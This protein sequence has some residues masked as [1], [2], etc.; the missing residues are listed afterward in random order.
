MVKQ[1]VVLGELHEIKRLLHRSLE[2][3]LLKENQDA[4]PKIIEK[5]A[6]HLL[7]DAARDHVVQIDDDELLDLLDFPRKQ[8]SK[9]LESQLR[10]L[11]AASS[12]LVDSAAAGAA[13]VD[14]GLLTVRGFK[15]FCSALATPGAK[16]VLS[17]YLQMEA[18]LF[19]QTKRVYLKTFEQVPRLDHVYIHKAAAE[20]ESDCHKI[21]KTANVSRRE[22]QLNTSLA[23]G[24]KMVY[25]RATFNADIVE[26]V[27]A[28]VLKRYHYWREHYQCR[29]Y[30]SSNILDVICVVLDTLASCHENI[31]RE[32]MIDRVLQAVSDLLED[33]PEES[34]EDSQDSEDSHDSAEES[35]IT[36][37]SNKKKPTPTLKHTPTPS[38]TQDNSAG[39]LDID[40]ALDEILC[41]SSPRRDSERQTLDFI[42]RHELVQRVSARFGKVQ[43]GTTRA[44]KMPMKQFVALLD[45]AMARR[46]CPY[47]ESTQIQSA[48]SGPEVVR[49]VY[50]NCRLAPDDSS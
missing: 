18:V 9:L 40:D 28:V 12:S 32:G 29:A 41:F 4:G 50:L 5:L 1:D 46:G 38:K 42:R 11:A 20:E 6:E 36:P 19:E 27:A 24:G 15:K 16:N 26:K 14:K 22:S 3:S 48:A 2:F 44:N 13:G 8:R 17:T 35:Q 33:S 37:A 47:A 21:G 31:S 25:S 45:D 23:R 7:V 34:A 49:R 39:D 43:Q 10:K 30:H